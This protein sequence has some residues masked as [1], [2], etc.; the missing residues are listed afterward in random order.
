V[1]HLCGWCSVSAALP[2]D[3]VNPPSAPTQV[4]LKQLAGQATYSGD[5]FS[6][7]G[8]SRASIVSRGCLS[9]LLVLAPGSGAYDGGALYLSR[10]GKK[11]PATASSDPG[12]ALRGWALRRRGAAG[13]GATS[14][15]SEEDDLGE[16]P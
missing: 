16:Q 9:D 5:L 11:A 8:E 14:T 6:S 7:R 10:R 3:N 4:N 2:H 15:T 12:A 13:P 1:H